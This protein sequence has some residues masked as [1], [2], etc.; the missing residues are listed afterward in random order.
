MVAST[1]IKF[2]VHSNTNAPQLQNAYGSMINVLDAC[3]VNG[4]GSQTV[5]T[6]TASGTTVTATFGSAHNFMQ[7]QVIKIA[8]ATQ[9]EYNG[10]H[11]ILTVPNANSITFQ[12]AAAPSVSTA[13]G[14]ISASLPPLGWE[15]PFSSVNANGGGKAVYRQTNEFLPSRPYL[16]VIDERDPLWNANYAKFAKVGIVEEM[17]DIDTMLGVQ[18]PFDG[19]APNKNWVATG[20]TTNSSTMNGW[21]KWYYAHGESGARH[22]AEP[23]ASEA[24]TPSVGAR[25]WILIGTSESFVIA[26]NPGLTSINYI[27]NGYGK[28]QTY[29]SGDLFN[30]YLA[31]VL[32][33]STA[34][35]SP[36]A[37]GWSQ[38]LVQGSTLNTIALSRK[39]NGDSL[40][41]MGSASAQRLTQTGSQNIT[42]TVTNLSEVIYTE[43]DLF[44]DGVFRGKLPFIRWLYQ[45]KPIANFSFFADED[46]VFLALNVEFGERRD[47]QMLLQVAEGL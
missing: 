30:D 34:S 24:N 32:W 23:N 5:S 13:T 11:R 12:L 35:Y 17:A 4:F 18:S 36:E 2:Y 26:V 19:A 27:V 43:V 16:R 31:G 21:M 44:A 15:K 46:K 45:L 42:D 47:G 1:D 33:N 29:Y 20:T 40:H 41:S 3:L 28:Y 22:V 10:E 6:L 37:K 8:G 9:T 39:L 38:G 25:S 7:Y 14:T